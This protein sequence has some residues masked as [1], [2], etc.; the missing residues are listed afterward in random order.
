MLVDDSLNR[1]GYVGLAVRRHEVGDI[2]D[3]L[4]RGGGREGRRRKAAEKNVAS[5][6][7]FDIS[8]A[9]TEL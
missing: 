8:R 6:L 3:A 1:V 9:F 5:N 4:R 2:Y 7:Q